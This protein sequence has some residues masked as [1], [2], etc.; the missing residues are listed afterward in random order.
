MNSANVR[1]LAVAAIGGWAAGLALSGAAATAQEGAAAADAP[2]ARFQAAA[3][4]ALETMIKEAEARGMKGVAVVAFVPGDTTRTWT[5]QMKAVDAIVLGNANV[6]AI[7]YCKLAE[8]ADTLQDS[9][10]QARP[11]L[12]GE[13]GYR[14]GA[15]R[16]TGGGF[17]LAA[18]SGGKDTDDLDVSRKG[19]DVLEK[20]AGAKA[21]AE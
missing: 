11:P 12:H 15:Y 10:S 4:R 2:A 6:L 9:G 8:M 13:L 21:A 5:S 3:P 16:K 14:G 19:L 7:A 17:F 18:F 1:R 20:P